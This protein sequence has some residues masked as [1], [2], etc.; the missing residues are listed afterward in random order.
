SG[1]QLGTLDSLCARQ[2]V[3]CVSGNPTVREALNNFA[4]VLTPEEG[5][6]VTTRQLIVKIL[7]D[8]IRQMAQRPDSAPADIVAA[9]QA[10]TDAQEALQNTLDGLIP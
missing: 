5:P 2:D 7:R 8:T 4:Y 3:T 1:G 10:V 9:Q 6:L